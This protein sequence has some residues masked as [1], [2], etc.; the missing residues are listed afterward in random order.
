MMSGATEQIARF[1]CGAS[2]RSMP[3]DAAQKGKKSLV[4]TFGVM[5]AGSATEVAP[6]VLRYVARS[7]APGQAAILGTAITTSAETAAFANGTF[8]HALDFDDVLPMMVAHP[9]SVILAAC[10]ANAARMK[11]SGRDLLE[12]YII[13]IETGAKIGLGMTVGHFGRGFHSQGTLCIFSAL[14][15]L[16]KLESFDVPT[17]QTAFGIASSMAS[18]LRCNVGTMTKPLHAGWAARSALAAT[19]LAREGFTAALDALESKTG[20]FAVYGVESSDVTITCRSLGAPWEIVDP[21]IALKRFPCCY[22]S[23]R[24][25]DGALTLRRQ[26]G[27]TAETLERLECRYPPGAT[28]S[29][30]SYPHPK[31]GLEGKFSLHYSLAAG[32][33]D[34]RYTLWTFTDEAVNRPALVPLLNKIQVKE[35][36]RC[37]GNDPLLATRSISGRGFV[38][39][40]AQT[41]DGG[42]ATVRVDHAPGHPARELSWDEIRAKFMDCAASAAVD[43]KSAECA[44]ERLGTLEDCGDIADVL[45]FFTKT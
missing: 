31:T 39:V 2:L 34:G 9:S 19:A 22:A 27:L 41:A 5:L 13:G 21:G 12:A 42:K 16:A 7:A 36:E 33:L 14:G 37:G 28:V 20:F 8:G 10:L 45:R 6:P 30:N 15:A 43:E 29:I 40:E 26:L 3:P 38:E 4:D 18:G 25:M 35:D 23:H 1:I 17:V 11:I 44:F 24:G 32:I